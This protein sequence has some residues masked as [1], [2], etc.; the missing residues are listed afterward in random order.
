MLKVGLNP[1]LLGTVRWFSCLLGLGLDSLDFLTF[2]VSTSEENFAIQFATEKGWLPEGGSV[3]TGLLEV[4]WIAECLPKDF[5]FQYFKWQTLVRCS[6][7]L[8][9]VCL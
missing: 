5:N 1:K 2:S 7:W 8:H 3:P 9:G 4:S 6:Y